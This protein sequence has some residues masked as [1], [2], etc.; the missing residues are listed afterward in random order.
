MIADRMSIFLVANIFLLFPACKTSSTLDSAGLPN[1]ERTQVFYKARTIAK[2]QSCEKAVD[3]LAELTLDNSIEAAHYLQPMLVSYGFDEEPGVDKFP[4][5]KYTLGARNSE[6][7]YGVAI[8]M[9]RSHAS[10]L[11]YP[12]DYTDWPVNDVKYEMCSTIDNFSACRSYAIERKFKLS[13]EQARML[14]EDLKNQPQ[15]KCRRRFKLS[16][17]RKY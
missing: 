10:R 1:V 2:K 9:F 8:D 15:F 11:I 7:D 14:W 6:S 17:L 16:K 13:S 3:Y 12:N 4:I 5:S